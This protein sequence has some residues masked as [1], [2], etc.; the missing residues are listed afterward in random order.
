MVT[1][2]ERFI[3]LDPQ[4]QRIATMIEGVE[5]YATQVEHAERYATQVQLP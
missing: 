1:F 4:Q 2:P 3:V 5:R